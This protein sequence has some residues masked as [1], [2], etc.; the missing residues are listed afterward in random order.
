[1]AGVSS[2]LHAL[3][4]SD[5]FEKIVKCNPLLEKADWYVDIDCSDCKHLVIDDV[6]YVGLCVPCA[7]SEG[8]FKFRIEAR[9]KFNLKNGGIF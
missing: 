1:M 3:K 2:G 7:R 6:H 4:V 5:C 9:I 8:E